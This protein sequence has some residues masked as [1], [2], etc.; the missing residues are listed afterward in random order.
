VSA[1]LQ[2]GE[3]VLLV[4]G[5]GRHYLVKLQPGMSFHYHLGVIP[6]AEFIG[7]EEGSWVP[8]PAG[9][10]LLVLRPRLADFILKMRRGAQVIYPKDSGQIITFA[11]VGPGM[12]VLEAGTGSGALT[13]S[14]LRAVGPTGRVVSVERREDHADFGRKTVERWHGSIP[15]NLE[16]RVG[17]VEP[18][19]EEVGPERLVLDIPEPWHAVKTAADHQPAGAVFCAYLPTVPQ[20][21]TLAETMRDIGA[22]AEIEVFETLHREWN[23]EGRSVRPAHVMVGHTGFVVVARRVHRPQPTAV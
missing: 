3:S 10:R 22:F 12:T 7:L 23:V 5:K 9:G 15:N 8:S 16:L 1:P 14:L 11:D 17:E 6:H 18:V 20:V 21:Q 2:A 4:D 19:V 13:L